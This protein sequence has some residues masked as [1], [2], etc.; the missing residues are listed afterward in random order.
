MSIGE[1]GTQ[2]RYTA[3]IRT[4]AEGALGGSVNSQKLFLLTLKK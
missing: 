1:R 4:W 2:G 3:D